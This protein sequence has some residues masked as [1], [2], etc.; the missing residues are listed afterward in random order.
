M[1]IVHRFFEWNSE[2]PRKFEDPK[3]RNKKQ[4]ILFC[5]PSNKSVDVVAGK[6]LCFSAKMSVAFLSVIIT[7][8]LCVS[9]TFVTQSAC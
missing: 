3:D 8:V 1:Y 7:H 4:V 9:F 5:G 6:L 2:N